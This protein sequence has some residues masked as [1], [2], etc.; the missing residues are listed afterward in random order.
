[1]PPLRANNRDHSQSQFQFLKAL[2]DPQSDKDTGAVELGY[3]FNYDYDYDYGVYRG[4][5]YEHELEHEHESTFPSPLI[6]VNCIEVV[7]HGHVSSDFDLSVYSNL[8]YTDLASIGI[9][10]DDTCNDSRNDHND[11]NDNANANPNATLIK[12]DGC[13]PAS[14]PSWLWHVANSL[15][16]M[17]RDS[18][19]GS[20]S[21][22]QTKA[23]SESRNGQISASITDKLS[24]TYENGIYSFWPDQEE[25]KNTHT[26]SRKDCQKMTKE[27]LFY[28][29]RWT[30]YLPLVPMNDAS[31]ALQ[32]KISKKRRI[33]MAKGMRLASASAAA[34]T[35]D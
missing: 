29:S 20:Y 31:T 14:P 8:T 22:T 17:D 33:R 23:Q 35:S 26:H 15:L 32:A 3:D 18:I 9:I 25:S 30:G 7:K 16:C 27:E 2:Q 19:C 5:E 4:D 10:S 34:V 11:H 13:A 1:M 21:N 24:D 12:L 6:G 28:A